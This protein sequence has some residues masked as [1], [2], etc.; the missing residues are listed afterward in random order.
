MRHQVTWKYD[1]SDKLSYLLKAKM[2]V[3]WSLLLVNILVTPRSAHF[4]LNGIKFWHVEN[5]DGHRRLTV[6][7]NNAPELQI[8]A[9]L[10]AEIFKPHKRVSSLTD[11]CTCGLFQY[12]PKNLANTHERGSETLVKQIRC[13]S[14]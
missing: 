5:G 3:R 7:F 9:G 1:M 8:T 13:R 12:A 6:H 14:V 10:L 2:E 11:S 4:P